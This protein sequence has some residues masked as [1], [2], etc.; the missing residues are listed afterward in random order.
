M[1]RPQIFQKFVTV[2]IG[3]VLIIGAFVA[4]S[5]ASS[6]LVYVND[7]VSWFFHTK[8]YELAIIKQ[9]FSSSAW[10]S[11]EA[12]DHP[13]LVKYIFGFVLWRFDKKYAF[14]RNALEQEIT[15]WDYY[16]DSEFSVY[17]YPELEKYL[18]V[19]RVY[20]VGVSSLTVGLFYSILMLI[21]R[22]RLYSCIGCGLLITNP[23]FQATMLRAI[24][25][26]TMILLVFT[27]IAVMLLFFR[28]Y[29]WKTALVSG[30]FLGSAISAKLSALAIVFG[31][32]L[33]M[34]LK[35]FIH[36]RVRSIAHRQFGIV[37]IIATIVWFGINPSLYSHGL[38]H[39]YEY[40]T[41]RIEQ[42]HKIQYAYP[43]FTLM[44]LSQKVAASF[45]VVL[46]PCGYPN[47]PNGRF[48]G[49]EGIYIT[50]VLAGFIRGI[51]AIR[52]KNIRD[53]DVFILSIGLQLVFYTV[54]YLP[55]AYDRYFLFLIPVVIGTCIVGMQEI[56]ERGARFINTL[57]KV[58]G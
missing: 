17:S 24:P 27:V 32:L 49:W 3:L 11:Y 2:A 37:L 13:P 33:F 31:L 20:Q 14:Y 19:L 41:F 39:S 30:I 18:S 54:I 10:Q 8:F 46:Y 1:K 23:L 56:R 15:R 22:S 4:F 7:E 28:S 58:K 42:T 35:Q 44:S 38:Q 25:D 45:C 26:G 9:D 55:L 51:R 29:S 52:I 16:Y 40:I 21:F 47:Y 50:L 43:E 36:S 48:I 57:A 34:V 53:P 5:R 6:S 12:Y